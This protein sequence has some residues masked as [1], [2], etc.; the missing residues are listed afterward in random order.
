MTEIWEAID[1]YLA[2]RAPK[3]WEKAEVRQYRQRIH[4]I[5][6]DN[7]RLISF[8]QSGSF[9]HGTAVTPYSDVDYMARIHFEDK[10]GSST[11]ILNK[12]R[13]CLKQELWEA[14]EVTVDRPTVTLKFNGF[15]TYYEITPAFLLRGSTDQDRVVAIPA[16]GGEWREAAP[17]A[18]NA[19][20]AEMDRKHH[21]DV[22]EIA[23]LLKAW[24]YEH[25]VPISSFFL[26]MRAAEYGKNSDSIWALASLRPIVARMID[27]NLAAMNDPTKLVSRITPCSSESSRLSAMARL[28]TLKKDLDTAYNAW[29]D[30]ASSRWEMNRA[31]QAIWGTGF[32]YADTSSS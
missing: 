15:V 6:N 27:S 24:K 32:P 20:V 19:F 16:S 12:I 18:H 3:S 17:Q 29:M 21:G 2:E 8:F 13:T 4:D 9:Q 26:E 10:P 23:R 5:L 28:R 30:G 22:R 14:A 25:G 31:L 11:T 7:F 1:Q